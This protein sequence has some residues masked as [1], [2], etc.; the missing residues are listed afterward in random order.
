MKRSLLGLLAAGLLAG[1]IAG[2]ADVANRVRL[3]VRSL[4]EI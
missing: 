1:P 2:H 3:L 4:K